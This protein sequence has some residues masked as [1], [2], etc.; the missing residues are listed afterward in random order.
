MKK[1]IISAI[2]RD[3]NPRKETVK[4]GRRERALFYVFL[5]WAGALRKCKYEALRP[6]GDDLDLREVC[7]R[8]PARPCVDEAFET[9]S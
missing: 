3:V 5:A 8:N 9:W 7:T 2:E 6:L 4:K 1:I